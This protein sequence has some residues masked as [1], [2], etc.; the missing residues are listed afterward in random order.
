MD[1]FNFQRAQDEW[2][3]FDMAIR[4]NAAIQVYK[5]RNS[6]V[7]L[8]VYLDKMDEELVRIS[9]PYIFISET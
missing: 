3:L 9:L 2:T 1:K 8:D 5:E 4:L 6:V 7:N